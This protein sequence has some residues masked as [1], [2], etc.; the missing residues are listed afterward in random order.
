VASTALQPVAESLLKRSGTFANFVKKQILTN[1]GDPPHIRARLD[2]QEADHTYRMAV[3]RLDRQRLGLEDRIE[4]TLK[5]LQRWELE[6]LRAVKD[7]EHHSRY[8]YYF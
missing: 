3:R 1:S 8:C 7:G 5:L 2:A 4:E 6:R